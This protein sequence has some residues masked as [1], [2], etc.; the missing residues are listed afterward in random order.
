MPGLLDPQTLDDFARTARSGQL[1]P[2][3]SPA[4][5][6]AGSGGAARPPAASGTAGGSFIPPQLARI[7]QQILVSAVK[8]RFATT[9]APDGARWRPLRHP[10]P[11]GGDVPLR[12]TG[13]LM[14]S[15]TGG[16]DATSV[17]VGTT[18]PGAAIHNFGGVVRGKNKMLA[19]PLTK[20]AKRSGGPRRWEATYGPLQFRPTRQ[21]RK[22]LLMGAPVKLKKPKAEKPTGEN[23]QAKAKP[24]RKARRWKLTGFIRKVFL[25]LRR[26]ARA[27]GAGGKPRKARTKVA[28]QV[29]AQF[30][31]VDQ[32]TIPAR[33]FMGLNEKAWD[34]IKDA[35][36]E[37]VARGWLASPVGF[38][39]SVG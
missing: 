1:A 17:W 7:Y 8:E 33:P 13:I 30:L 23:P 19:I 15:F 10:R 5:A 16:H 35:T 36:A 6:G 28:A 25:L 2:Q 31:L 26:R 9:S 22:F 4:S 29:V 11:N 20:E 39:T 12:D 18:H 37:A 38:G 32:V 14:A 21:G 3:L 34:Q 24:R 27:K